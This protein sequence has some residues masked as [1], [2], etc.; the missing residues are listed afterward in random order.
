[1][2]LPY[3]HPSLSSQSPPLSCVGIW[4][5]GSLSG[6]QVDPC[7]NVPLQIKP[8]STSYTRISPFLSLWNCVLTFS[9]VNG[10]E[11]LYQKEKHHWQDKSPVF[12]GKGITHDRKIRVTE[13]RHREHDELR[14]SVRSVFKYFHNSFNSIRILASDFASGNTWQGQIPY[15]LDLEAAKR[16]NVSMLYTSELYGDQKSD[17]PVFNSLALES[18][19]RNVPKSDPNIDVMVYLND[20]MFLASPHSV[21]DFWNPIVGMN[22]QVDHHSWVENEDASVME[23]QH[24]WNS[25][26]TALRYTNFLLSISSIK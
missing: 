10:S 20:D 21:T 19:F 14:Y 23:F 8:K 24:D 17:L 9:W 12:G 25:E 26:W 6:S 7:Q 18:Q 16:Y 2:I 3:L 15:W 1:M 13:R 11:P 5:V 22:F 4:T